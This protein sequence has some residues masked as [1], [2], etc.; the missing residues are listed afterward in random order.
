MIYLP[1]DPN[2]VYYH[3]FLVWREHLRTAKMIKHNGG[4]CYAAL[5]ANMNYVTELALETTRLRKAG[6]LKDE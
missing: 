1:F 5:I 3:W 4:Y 6:L 2:A